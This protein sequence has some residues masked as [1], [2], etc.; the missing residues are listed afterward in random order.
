MFGNDAYQYLKRLADAGRIDKV[1]RGKYVPI[2]TPSEQSGMS[3][4]ETIP[5]RTPHGSDTPHTYDNGTGAANQ[6]TGESE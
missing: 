1:N 3:G 2:T 4:R 5:R 6:A